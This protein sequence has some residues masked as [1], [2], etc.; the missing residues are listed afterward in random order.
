MLEALSYFSAFV[1]LLKKLRDFFSMQKPSIENTA[2]HVIISSGPNSPIYLNDNPV[3]QKSAEEKMQKETTLKPELRL[4]MLGG[5]FFTTTKPNGKNI[6]GIALTA[7][8]W[9]TGTPSIVSDWSLMIIP[10]G[11]TPIR[12]QLAQIPERLPV[13]GLYSSPVLRASDA[14]DSK[15]K[16]TQVGRTPVEG[17]LLFYVE[18]PLNTV[19]DPNTRLE[20]TATDEY[21]VETS[22]KVK[23]MGDWLSD[24]S[25]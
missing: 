22:P 13:Q 19:L 25:V 2:G 11:A 16:T 17:T 3:H 4:S 14:L 9:N 7:R 10:Q 20:L 18:L 23:R 1:S 5:N 6:T 12:A 8:V 24:G 21:E 15:V